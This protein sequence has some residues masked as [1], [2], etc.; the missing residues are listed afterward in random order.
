[1]AHA[2]G[3]AVKLYRAEKLENPGDLVDPDPK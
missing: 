3:D 2:F 1:V